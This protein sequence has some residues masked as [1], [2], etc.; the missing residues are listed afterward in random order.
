MAIAEISSLLTEFHIA[1]E[2][3]TLKAVDERRRKSQ[4]KPPW[5]YYGGPNSDYNQEI[6]QLL[7]EPVGNFLTYRRERYGRVFAM[8]VMGPGGFSELGKIDGEVAVTLVDHR[9]VWKKLGDDLFNIHTVKG[10]LLDGRTWKRVKT[11]M[12]QSSQQMNGGFDIITLIPWGGWT[13][14]NGNLGIAHP[15]LQ[16]LIVNRLTN[17]LSP[18]S[19]VLLAV[20][21]GG[22]GYDNWIT[23]MN[24]DDQVHALGEGRKIR[25]IRKT[26][27]KIHLPRISF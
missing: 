18:K 9:S 24:Q 26:A 12:E 7:D 8:D 17:L 15:D 27:E 3:A 16:W 14:M 5:P 6:C 20:M 23:K 25:I 1:R 4:G 2:A 22:V 11:L 21:A 10:D 19:G 13:V